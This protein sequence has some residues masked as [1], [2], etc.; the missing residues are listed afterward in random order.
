MLYY[1]LKKQTAGEA[2][3]LDLEEVAGA[4]GAT[5]TPATPKKGSSRSKGGAK[6]E[7]KVPEKL[8]KLIYALII[9]L[10]WFF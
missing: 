8:K 9:L 2:V 6:K 3:D 5:V 4:T 7:K 10:T 1:F